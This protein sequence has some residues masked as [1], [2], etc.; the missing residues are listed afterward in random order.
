MIY[1]M[2]FHFD[3]IRYELGYIAELKPRHLAVLCISEIMSSI[4][5]MQMNKLQVIMQRRNEES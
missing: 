1:E 4:L 5:I 3:F 2:W